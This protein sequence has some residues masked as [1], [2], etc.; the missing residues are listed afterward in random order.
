MSPSFDLQVDGDRR[1]TGESVSGTVVVREGGRSRS[2]EVRLEFVEETHPYLEVAIS[3]ASGHLH[4]GRL[5]PGMA[6]PFT[7][8]V[9]PDALPSVR[10]AHGELY[11]RLD[12]RSDEMGADSHE[13]RR[14]VVDV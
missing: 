3:I 6:F 13:L 9:P 2:L 11:W 1:R 4:T 5:E 8:A 14:I 10:S 12:A 7:L